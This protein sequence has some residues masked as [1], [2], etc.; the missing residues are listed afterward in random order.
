VSD[1]GALWY[2]YLLRCADGS[3][4]TGITTDVNARVKKHNQGKGA[5]YTSGRRPV[6]VIYQEQC[7]DQ[8][9]AL[10]REGQIKR[11]RKQKKEDLALGFPER[12]TR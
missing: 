12:R 9:S 2:V 7:P 5:A 10:R 4:Y 11:W 1:M 3:I 6:A 8:G